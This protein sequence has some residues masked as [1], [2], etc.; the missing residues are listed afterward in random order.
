MSIN[1]VELERTQTIWRIRVAC[2]IS[3]HTPNALEHARAL[4]HTNTY[5]LL[6]FHTDNDSQTLFNITLDVYGLSCLEKKKV[7]SLSVTWLE[8]IKWCFLCVRTSDVSK[9]W[10]GRNSMGISFKFYCSW[11][12]TFLSPHPTSTFPPPPPLPPP[13]ISLWRCSCPANTGRFRLAGVVCLKPCLI[14]NLVSLVDLSCHSCL[15]SPHAHPP[16]I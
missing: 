4:T 2:W 3:T 5:Y 11:A 12:S 15:L 14:T 13:N 8:G 7:H 9:K 16:F 6:L 1:M 10:R